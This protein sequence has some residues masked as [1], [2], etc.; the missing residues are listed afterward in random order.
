MSMSLPS[1]FKI[2]DG[3]FSLDF[4]DCHGILGVSLESD[5]NEMRK[6]YMKIARRLH[7]DTCPFENPADK[8]LAN[9]IL[10]KLVSPAYNKFAKES[11]RNEYALLLKTLSQQIGKDKS[12]LK[13]K[14]EEAN[15]LAE[16]KDLQSSYQELLAELAE[17][18][19]EDINKSLE[20]TGKISELNLVYLLR[21]EQKGGVATSAPAKPA[22]TAPKEPVPPPAA[23]TL[24][25]KEPPKDA[26]FEES[27]RRAEDFIKAKNY[28]KA[29]LELKE[30]IKRQPSSDRA[31]GLIGLS[32]LKQDQTTMAKIHV[33]KALELNPQ[34]PS[35][36]EAKKILDKSEPVG[37]K[38]KTDNKNKSG[39]KSNTNKGDKQTDSK[40]EITNLLRRIFGDSIFGISLTGGAKDTKGKDAKGK[41]AKGKD[42]K[43]K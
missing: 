22:T 43:K 6:R 4:T 28:G 21:K 31:H 25:P 35:A 42:K 7:T 11:D 32:Y 36:L 10:S 29:I 3:L 37:K 15:K 14:S 8:D 26:L 41:D 34:E 18:Q 23:V 40:S 38:G 39:G 27:Y 20:I 5:F 17:K 13:W 33:K 12:K 16:A 30:A 24:T 9:Q 1:L 19:Y 2:T